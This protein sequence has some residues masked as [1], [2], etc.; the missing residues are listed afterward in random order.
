MEKEFSDPKSFLSV[1]SSWQ[2]NQ[3]KQ[4]VVDGTLFN[5]AT[6]ISYK[7]INLKITYTKENGKT[8]IT[9]FTVYETLPPGQKVDFHKNLVDMF[10][11]T[12]DLKVEIDNVEV[13]YP[14][15]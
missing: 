10:T 4:S 2:K 14:S 11:N 12:K 7:N 6:V 9:Y 1:K 5:S 3:F 13:V 15:K 8:Y